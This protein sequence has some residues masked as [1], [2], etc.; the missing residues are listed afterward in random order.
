MTKSS[1]LEKL[2]Y[3]IGWWYLQTRLWTF[4][5]EKSFTDTIL[6]SMFRGKQGWQ[7]SPQK[8]WAFKNCHWLALV[9]W[10]RVPIYALEAFLDSECLQLFWDC[11]LNLTNT[12]NTPGFRW[13]QLRFKMFRCI[14]MKWFNLA[15]LQI[16]KLLCRRLSSG[17]E[18]EEH[19][20]EVVFK[21]IFQFVHQ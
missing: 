19:E 10:H 8:N 7:N 4:R 14:C 11:Q 16:T 2:L 20:L 6:D 3:F 21:N 1:I 5:E 15:L 13:F 9:F 18:G 17:S 12:F